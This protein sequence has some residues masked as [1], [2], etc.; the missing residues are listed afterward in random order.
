MKMT[1]LE[2]I[3]IAMEKCPLDEQRKK[4]IQKLACGCRPNEM[5]NLVDIAD[6]L[7]SIVL[8]NADN[9]MLYTDEKDVNNSLKAQLEESEREKKE[10]LRQLKEE[11]ANSSNLRYI[12]N[13]HE[14]E[15][16]ELKDKNRLLMHAHVP[17]YHLNKEMLY[18]ALSAC[19]ANAC[20][21]LGLS[22]QMLVIHMLEY[23]RCGYKESVARLST[24]DFI[25]KVKRAVVQTHDIGN[26]SVCG[27]AEFSAEHMPISKLIQNKG[28]LNTK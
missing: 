3:K 12:C 5:L 2:K 13:S 22:V 16:K 26:V 9:Y 24:G 23:V 25:V 6:A 15:I 14:E 21:W 18:Q 11:K 10:L 19:I 4:E 17:F 8:Q 7:Q 27:K 28:T 20:K 1:Y